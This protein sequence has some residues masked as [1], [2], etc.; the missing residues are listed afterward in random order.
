MKDKVELE[1]QRK[2]ED[3]Q[4]FSFIFVSL[5]FFMFLGIIIPLEGKNNGVDSILVLGVFAMLLLACTCHFTSKRA[6]T[7]L[8]ERD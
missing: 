1:L 4:R 2:I 8:L 3:Y 5:S 6:L 7:Q